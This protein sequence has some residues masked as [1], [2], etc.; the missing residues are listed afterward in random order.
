MWIKRALNWLWA[1]IR[2]PLDCPQGKPDCPHKGKRSL[3]DECLKD[4][5]IR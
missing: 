5:V 2:Q 1:L 4:W 3:C